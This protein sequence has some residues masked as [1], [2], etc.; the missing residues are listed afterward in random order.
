MCDIEC[1]VLGVWL[2]VWC[3]VC[4]VGCVMS[5]VWNWLFDFQCTML[6]VWCQS[7][8]V[9]RV[10]MTVQMTTAGTR[11][12]Y[13]KAHYGLQLTMAGTHQRSCRPKASSDDSR[14]MSNS[15][16]PYRAQ[17]AMARIR[18]VGCVVLSVWYWVC[19]VE[20][21]M[22]GVW[23][24][25]CMIL[26]VWCQLC[27]I[28]CVMLSV[29]CQLCDIGCVMLSVWCRMC[30]VG[31]VMLGVWVW[32]CDVG[33]MILSVNEA[34]SIVASATAEPPIEC[35]SQWQ[36]HTQKSRRPKASIMA[37]ATAEPPIECKSQ[38]QRYT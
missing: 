3:W 5:G 13:S 25:V 37:S 14:G 32:V 18:N 12:N 2:S 15:R 30:D 29:W 4:G 23:Y 27:D 10:I 19:H 35:K 21:V 31:C 6:G 24:W 38:W 8:D 9:G 36:G 33:S 34:A 22:S 17:N 20:C 7:W 16:A 26:R 11:T 28:G 1:V